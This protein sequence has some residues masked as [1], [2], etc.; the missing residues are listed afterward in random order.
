[1]PPGGFC[2]GGAE[3]DPPILG[4]ERKIALSS[5]LCVRTPDA[6]QKPYPRIFGARVSLKRVPFSPDGFRT[7]GIPRRFAGGKLKLPRLFAL[8]RP[9]CALR[10]RGG[11][12]TLLRRWGRLGR[13]CVFIA[14]SFWKLSNKFINFKF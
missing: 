6:Q 1:M 10:G 14:S 8:W 5:I 2:I 4:A 3:F 13:R 7:K 12:C 11:I 9:L